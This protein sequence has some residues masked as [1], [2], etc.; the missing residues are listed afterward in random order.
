MPI[1]TPTTSIKF[2][3][4][5]YI[6]VVMYKAY[7]VY[8]MYVCLCFLFSWSRKRNPFEYFACARLNVHY[9]IRVYTY[10]NVSK[11]AISYRV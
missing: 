3:F 5:V 11:L 9:N 7:L 1:K 6:S 4:C 2:P 8:C 10:T